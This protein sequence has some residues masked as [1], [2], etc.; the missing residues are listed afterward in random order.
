MQWV[1]ITM[2][3]MTMM[4][5]IICRAWTYY[6]WCTCRCEQ[7]KKQFFFFLKTKQKQS[8]VGLSICTIHVENICLHF[9]PPQVVHDGRLQKP[10]CFRRQRSSPLGS[11]HSIHAIHLLLRGVHVSHLQR[12]CH[13]LCLRLQLHHH[14]INLLIYLRL[15]LIAYTTQ[16][17]LRAFP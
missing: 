16:G 7:K 15:I 1:H 10:E 3:V 13:T 9:D 12:T 17:H 8:K 11:C 14:W 5:M 2:M 6:T 4:M